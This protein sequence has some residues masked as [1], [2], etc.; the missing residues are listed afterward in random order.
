MN[1]KLLAAW[2]VETRSR[3]F[4][5]TSQNGMILTMRINESMSKMVETTWLPVDDVN[6]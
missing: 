3:V 2:M 4:I 5:S 1:E 6:C